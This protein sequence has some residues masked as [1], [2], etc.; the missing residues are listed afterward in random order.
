MAR[1]KLTDRAVEA[2]KAKS[3]ERVELWDTHTT[4]LC[5][6]VSA[7]TKAWVVRYRSDGKQRRYVFGDFK[8]MGLADARIE[9]ATILRS[10]KKTGAD[11]AGDSQRARAEVK[12]QPIKTFKQLADAYM[13]ACRNGEWKPKGKRQSERTLKDAEG[14]LSRHILPELGHLKLEDVTRAVV[15]KF[16][17]G[18][19]A[20]GIG[21]QTNK[22]L[23]V[24]RQTYSYA[25]AEYEGKLVSVNVATGQPREVETPGTRVLTDAEIKAL[26]AALKAPEGLRLPPADEGAEPARVYLSRPMAILLQLSLLLLQRRNELAGM[27]VSEVNLDEAVWL[28]PAPRMKARKPHLVPLPPASVGLIRE[29]IQLAVATLP[30]P[31]PGEARP[32]PNDFPVFPSPRDRTRPIQPG[33]VT[34]AL[35][36]VMTALGIAG[37]SPHDLRRTGSTILTSERLGVSPFVRSRV[38]SHGSDTGGGAAVSSVHYDANPYAAEKRRAL[39][40]WEDLLLEIVGERVRPSNVAPMKQAV[41]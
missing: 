14:S 23:A 4:G 35:A 37:A 29:A 9:A 13:D 12:A 21:A 19:A 3:G 26:W 40:A 39:A 25:I 38:L 16:L 27:M 20:K 17:R 32:R 36:P 30:A 18:M 31:E 6:R 34:H 15:R 2:A 5:L 8:D 22:A 10:V 41:G 24:I 7:E 1:L 11:P 28:I 33:S